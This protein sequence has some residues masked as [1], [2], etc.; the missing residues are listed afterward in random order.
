MSDRA[1]QVQAAHEPRANHELRCVWLTVH[2]QWM[3]EVDPGGQ[4]SAQ[5]LD[6]RDL[7]QTCERRGCWS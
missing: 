3:Y 7:L 5:L 4:L 1:K 2:A 6:L